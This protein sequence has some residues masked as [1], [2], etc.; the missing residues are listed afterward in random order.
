VNVTCP[1]CRSIFRIDPA[2]VPTAGV[3][4]RCSVCGGVFAVASAGTRVDVP[5]SV[6]AGERADRV[7]AT[8]EAATA[9]AGPAMPAEAA[10]TPRQQELAPMPGA[11]A[12]PAPIA[13]PS[14]SA[15]AMPSAAPAPS[16]APAASAAS[17]P[18]ASVPP[19]APSVAD[20][21][22]R[23]PVN[24]YLSNDPGQKARRL[25][26]ALVSDLV[27]Y[28]PQKREEGLRNG[29]LKELFRDE[30]RKSWEEYVEQVGSDASENSAHFQDALNDPLAAGRR[31][32]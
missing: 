11:D 10:P 24:P 12:P 6:P 16:S 15:P 23:R 13:T 30:I 29:T 26:R 28:N 31:V 25:A 20:A 18:S 2:K 1:D 4:T 3:R 17:A 5:V 27:A 9:N 21:A 8:R 32:F 14:A 7:E 19:A 22:P